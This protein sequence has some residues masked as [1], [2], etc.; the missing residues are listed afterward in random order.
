MPNLDLI[1]L[2]NLRRRLKDRLKSSDVS[3]DILDLISEIERVT[4]R[5][6]TSEERR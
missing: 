3:P 5:L 4:D 2:F 6:M 1:R